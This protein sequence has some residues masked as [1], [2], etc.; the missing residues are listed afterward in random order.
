MK[1][2]SKW[3]L[4]EQGRRGAKNLRRRGFEDKDFLVRRR[5]RVLTEERERDRVHAK[6]SADPDPSIRS[7]FDAPIMTTLWKARDPDV[8]RIKYGL[9]W[10]SYDMGAGQWGVPRHRFPHVARGTT[11]SSGKGRRQS[12]RVTS[13]GTELMWDIALLGSYEREFSLRLTV[14]NHIYQMEPYLTDLG[15]SFVLAFCEFLSFVRSISLAG[16]SSARSMALAGRLESPLFSIQENGAVF[17]RKSS[18][19]LARDARRGC[20]S[21]TR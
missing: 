19:S 9:I 20:D 17:N 14:G 2:L 12:E 13:K 16:Q 7:L 15:S 4:N 6:A 8:D 3:S 10:R 1:S 11:N 5:P 18:F 21:A